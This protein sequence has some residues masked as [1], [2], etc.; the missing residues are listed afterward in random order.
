MK[1]ENEA[2]GWKFELGTLTQKKA[3]TVSDAIYTAHKSFISGNSTILHAAIEAEWLEKFTTEQVDDADPAQILWMATEI[4][5]QFV[6]L[7]T[8]PKA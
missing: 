5:K 4:Q 6:K 2:N 1:F 8:I 7:I 3:A